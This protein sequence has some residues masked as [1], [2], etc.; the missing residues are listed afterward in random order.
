MIFLLSR[1]SPVHAQTDPPGEELAMA[2]FNDLLAVMAETTEIATRTRLN[3]DF[4]PGMVTVLKGKELESQGVHTLKE[5]LNLVPGVSFLSSTGVLSVRGVGAWSSGKVKLL[6]NGAPFNDTIFAQGK[7]LVELPIEMVERIEV[8]RGPG[9]AVY[10]EYALNG[11]VNVITRQEGQRLHGR[12]GSFNTF[13][14]GGLISREQGDWRISLNLAGWNSDGDDLVAEADNLT[15]LG[16]GFA[17]GLSNEKAASRNAILTVRHHQTELLAQFIQ[18]NQGDQFGLLTLLP[19]PERRLVFEN[20]VGMLELKQGVQ[21]ST[22]LAIELKAGWMQ[23]IYS[24]DRASYAPAPA[25]FDPA[26][27]GVDGSRTGNFTATDQKH[28]IGMTA[29]WKHFEHHLLSFGLDWSAIRLRDVHTSG[30]WDPVT[31]QATATVTEFPN[32]NN[33]LI[34]DLGR[35]KL[36]GVMIQDQWE[37]IP[38]LTSTLGLRYDHYSDVGESLTPRIALVYRL[39]DHHILK[40][41]YGTA[42][43]PPAFMEMYAN[44]FVIRANPDIQPEKIRTYDLGYIYR[45][46]TLV[47]RIT[48]FWTRMEDLISLDT[49]G[50]PYYTNKSDVSMRGYELELETKLSTTLKTSI[51]LSHVTTEDQSTGHELAGVAPWIANLAV[52][53]QPW[54]DFSLALSSRHVSRRHR[55]A[56]DNRTELASDTTIN[57]T[58]SVFNCGMSGLTCQSGVKNLFDADVREFASPSMPYDY[59]RNGRELWLKLAYD[60]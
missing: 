27:P 12:Y 50:H 54:P 14:G 39:A 6:L 19:P 26:N 37:I 53:H 60:F 10:G 15:P 52:T 59:P 35:R 46:A 57:L 47:G 38:Q 9:A 11:V 16:L 28:Y 31:D 22:E 34:E 18:S 5:A 41:Q 56:G 20:Q 45:D 40:A 25:F 48:G 1:F 49:T 24:G 42:F 8:I 29:D 4:V 33:W 7:S 55:E 44:N 43:R 3:A 58:G 2:G 17:P 36:F 32:A 30:N 51:N 21:P 23:T 13:A